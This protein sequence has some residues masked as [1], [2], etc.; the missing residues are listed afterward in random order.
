M[1]AYVTQL[2]P[3]SLLLEPQMLLPLLLLPLP[4]LLPLLLQLPPLP[5][6]LPLPPP[7]PLLLLLLLLLRLP[8]LLPRLA[9]RGADTAVFGTVLQHQSNILKRGLRSSRMIR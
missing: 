2:F 5:L 6:P 1:I 4:L 8:Q 7:P 3:S 9:N